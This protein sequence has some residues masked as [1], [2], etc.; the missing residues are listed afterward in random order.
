MSLFAISLLL[1]VFALAWPIWRALQN[2][3]ASATT[4]QRWVTWLARLFPPVLYAIGAAIALYLRRTFGGRLADPGMWL[5]SLSLFGFLILLPAGYLLLVWLDRH[6]RRHSLRRALLSIVLLL[7]IVFA[8]WSLFIGPA[9]FVE[10]HYTITTPRAPQ[11]P[12]TILHVSDLQTDGP[13]GRERLMHTAIARKNPDLVLFTGDLMND[14]DIDDPTHVD[15]VIGSAKRFVAALHAPLGVYG[16]FGDWDGW[17]DDWPKQI[18]TILSGSK[19]K[20]L[21]SEASFCARH[22]GM[23]SRCSAS[24]AVLAAHPSARRSP[25]PRGCAS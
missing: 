8:S 17:G 11:K 25:T 3:R 15:N 7:P 22:R 16:V 14:P 13:C 12:L 19:M 10:R 5:L 9:R 4:S 21:R 1:A 18:D 23:P 6:Q 24:M 2:R 20:M